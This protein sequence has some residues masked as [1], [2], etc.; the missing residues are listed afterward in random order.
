[1]ALTSYL[2]FQMVLSVVLG[3]AVGLER[4]KNHKPAGMRTHM[5]VC[6]GACLFTLSSVSVIFGSDP[7]RVAASIVTGVGF[8]GA[9]T[10]IASKDR[11]LGITTA[12]SL[13]TT[14]AI[15]LLVGIG[16]A[17]IATV[18]TGLAIFILMSDYLIKKF[19]K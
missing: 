9:G 19:I 10:I 17:G 2:I 12:A 1:M 14:A 6:F 15:G 8:I 13:W 18:A 11:V 7:A 16:E 3:A 5:C 4:E